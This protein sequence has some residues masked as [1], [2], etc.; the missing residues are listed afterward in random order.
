M[1]GALPYGPLSELYGRVPVILIS[2][3]FFLVFNIASGFA[4]TKTQLLIFR[5]LSAIGG[6]AP[7][8]VSAD[9]FPTSYFPGWEPY[10]LRING[11]RHK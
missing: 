2:F 6:S 11:R 8:T 4:Q 1:V 5:L 3:F 7:N 10:M 9:D